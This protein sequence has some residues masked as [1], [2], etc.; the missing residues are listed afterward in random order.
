MYCFATF[1]FRIELGGLATEVGEKMSLFRDCTGRVGK[2]AQLGGLS[3]IA[4][5][6]LLSHF[7]VMPFGRKIFFLNQDVLLFL[8]HPNLITDKT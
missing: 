2:G 1:F 3:Y 4:A 6:E 7:L 5:I 8:S